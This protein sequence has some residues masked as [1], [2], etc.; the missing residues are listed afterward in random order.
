M[1]KT[2]EKK[3]EELLN[4]INNQGKTEGYPLFVMPD[5]EILKTPP[6]DVPFRFIISD[7]LDTAKSLKD[8]AIMDY[9]T[10]LKRTPDIISPPQRP[11]LPDLPEM[12][13]IPPHLIP[14]VYKCGN[15]VEY[16]Y[17]DENTRRKFTIEHYPDK[18]T[19]IFLER[20]LLNKECTVI[21]NGFVKIYSYII[22]KTMDS[23][24]VKDTDLMRK[25]SSDFNPMLNTGSSGNFIQRGKWVAKSVEDVKEVKTF[26]VKEADREVFI[27]I[28]E[29]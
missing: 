28:F 6:Q 12:F 13:Q 22:P 29:N 26:H 17:A 20:G 5:G 8:Q 9:E 11:D 27:N 2:L 18:V 4:R 1:E 23:T 7:E 10:W 21:E 3:L 16:V 15:M 14:E 24:E 25:Q 19:T